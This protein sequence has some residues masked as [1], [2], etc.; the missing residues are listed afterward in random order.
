MLPNVSRKQHDSLCWNSKNVNMDKELSLCSFAYV[1]ASKQTSVEVFI[2]HMETQ[3]G[4]AKI[5]SLKTEK[6]SKLEKENVALMCV[7]QHFWEHNISIHG[8]YRAAT[9]TQPRQCALAWSSQRPPHWIWWR[10]PSFN[11]TDEHRPVH[12]IKIIN[13]PNLR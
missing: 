11:H 13:H 8:P 5:H 7:W 6:S 10:I 1:D 2:Q 12:K 4:V 3:R 9:S